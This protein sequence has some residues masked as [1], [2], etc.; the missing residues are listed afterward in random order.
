MGLQPCPRWRG[1]LAQTCHVLHS[2]TLGVVGPSSSASAVSHHR[3][4]VPAS[5]LSQCRISLY[6]AAW[7]K[8]ILFLET[9]A[10]ASGLC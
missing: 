8:L 9:N 1:G 3:V 10:N 2:I 4:S 7:R 6:F 5:L